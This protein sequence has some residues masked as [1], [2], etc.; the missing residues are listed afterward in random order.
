[1]ILVIIFRVGGLVLFLMP[2]VLRKFLIKK[3]AA[4]SVKRSPEKAENVL[5]ILI[6]KK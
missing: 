1:M 5:K 2:L 6:T 4:W 3:I